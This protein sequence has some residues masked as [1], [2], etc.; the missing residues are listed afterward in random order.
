LSKPLKIQIVEL[1]R[2]LIADEQH[3][4]RRHLAEDG[5]GVSVSPISS[6][7]VKRCGL[8]AVIAA[9]YQLTHDFDAAYKLGHDLLSPIFHPATLMQVND[10]KGHAAVLALFDQV[11]AAS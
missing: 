8:G 5:N 10:T 7:A 2:T 9:A 1:A 6:S 4:C 11:T 3:W